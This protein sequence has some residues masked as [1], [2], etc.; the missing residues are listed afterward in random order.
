[1]KWCQDSR[2]ES[3]WSDALMDQSIDYYEVLQISVNADAELIQRVF[4]L[5]ARRYHPDNLSSGNAT[6]FRQLH[7][8]YSVLSDVENGRSTMRFTKRDGTST[9]VWLR[10]RPMRRTTSS[11]SRR[12]G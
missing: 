2:L 9:V 10:A 12:S 1:M 4:R 5:L 7:E 11:P 8:A 6:V 3:L